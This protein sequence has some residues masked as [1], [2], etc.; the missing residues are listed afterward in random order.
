M[1]KVQWINGE[2]TVFNYVVKAVP[3][4]PELIALKDIHDQIRYYISV[5][6]IRYVYND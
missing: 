4:S 3:I 5:K 2:E 1:I 6:G